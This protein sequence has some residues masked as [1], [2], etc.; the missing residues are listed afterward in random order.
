MSGREGWKAVAETAARIGAGALGQALLPGNPVIGRLAGA[1]A[2]E[3]IA[4]HLGVDHDDVPPLVEK[5]G[6]L[7]PDVQAALRETDA[8][9]VR[10]GGYGEL[11]LSRNFALRE[12]ECGHCGQLAP[13]SLAVFQESLNALQELREEYGRPMRLTSAWRCLHHPVEE[14][15]PPDALHRH[16]CAAFDVACHTLAQD[17][18]LELA[19]AQGGWTGKGVKARGPMAGRFL[20]LDRLAHTPGFWGY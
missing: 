20:H 1:A 7:A 14:K 9:I 6:A 15:K 18:L 13:L 10:E 11:R 12:L 4:A 5:G 3:A 16:T 2:S 17:R 19:Y 8:A